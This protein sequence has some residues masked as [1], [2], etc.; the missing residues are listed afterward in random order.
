MFRWLIHH[1]ER[2]SAQGNVVRA[3][4]NRGR[5]GL[6]VGPVLAVQ[7][8]VGARNELDRLVAPTK[9]DALGFDDAEADLWRQALPPLLDRAIHGFWTHEG[10]LLYDLQRVC[11]DHE[12]E[13]FTVDLVEWATSLGRVPIKRTLP[14]LREVLMSNYLRGASRRLRS[15]RI[16]SGDRARLAELIHP[17]VRHAEHALRE[18]FRP[19][20][21]EV[22]CSTQILAHN[23]P[24]D[25]AYHKLIEE[26]LDRIVRRGFLSLGDLRDACSRS[27]LKLPDLSGRRR[28]PQRRSA[29]PDRP[30]AGSG[31]RRRLPSRRNLPPRSPAAQ[32]PGVRDPAGGDS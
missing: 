22:L 11:I 9:A 31:P 4:F 7:A 15:A 5:A 14:H 26:L 18:R 2:A 8:S 30:G 20:I 28:V 13:V 12:R 16:D 17:A 25:V 24:E 21:A 3:A 23:L 10:R 29:A 1:A 27:N 19:L 32:H 6:L